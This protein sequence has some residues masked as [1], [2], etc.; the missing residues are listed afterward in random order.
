MMTLDEIKSNIDAGKRVYWVNKGY[1][2]IKD[3]IGQYLIV[4]QPNGYTICL[5]W[6]DGVTMNGKEHEF[7]TD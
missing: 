1:Q 6:A 3:R 4:F 2:V 7:F 5:T